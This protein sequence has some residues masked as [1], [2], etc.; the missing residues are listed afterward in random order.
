MILA[1]VILPG[2]SWWPAVA[3]FIAVTIALLA[4]S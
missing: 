3:A 4:W 1:T 2:L